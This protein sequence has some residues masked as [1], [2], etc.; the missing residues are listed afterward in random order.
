MTYRMLNAGE[1]GLVVELGDT[2][3]P[4][5]NRR[6][7]ALADG[8]RKLSHPSIIEIVPSYR[9]L[10]IYFDP[11][12]LPRNELCSMAISILGKEEASTIA[13]NKSRTIVIPVCYGGDFGPDLAFVAEYARLKEKEVIAKHSGSS[14]LV[15]ML[16]FMPGFPYLGGLPEELAVPRLDKPRTK[17]PAG[18]VA[19]AGNQ[20]GFY[21]LESPGG[22]RLIGRTPIFSLA[23]PMNGAPLFMQGDYLK[24]QAISGSRYEKILREVETGRYKAEVIVGDG[25]GP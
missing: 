5:L 24:F 22:W 17:I 10:L 21:P 18:S 16:G 6:V 4:V 13:E 12:S 9:S 19:I 15:Y 14:Y 1:Q 11:L 25:G 3:D 2:I 20:T 7:R 8:I 23:Y